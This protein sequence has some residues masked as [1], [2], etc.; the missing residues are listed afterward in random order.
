MASIGSLNPAVIA[1]MS[2]RRPGIGGIIVA[3]APAAAGRQQTRRQD[4]RSR[5]IG[6]FRGS[7][8]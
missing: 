3:P 7:V 2:K 1:A 4:P 5:R 6:P 8:A